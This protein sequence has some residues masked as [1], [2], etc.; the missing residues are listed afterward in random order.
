MNTEVIGRHDNRV[1]LSSHHLKKTIPSWIVWTQCICFAVLYAIWNYPLTNFLS[2]LCMIVGALLSVYILYINRDFFRTKQAIP[3]WLLVLLL[4]WV[5]FHLLFLSNNFSLQ[6]R[7]LTNIWKRVV[8]AIIFALGFG[9]ALANSKAKKGYWILFYIGMMAPALIFIGKYW[10]SISAQKYGWVVPEYLRIYSGRHSVFYMYKTDYVSFCLPALAITLA[11]LRSKLHDS[12][13]NLVSNFSYI[14]GVSAIM[15]TFYL[16]N[17]KNGMAYSM[18]LIGTFLILVFNFELNKVVGIRFVGH[19]AKLWLLK[20]TVILMLVLAAFPIASR[21]IEQNPSWSSIW[22]DSKVAVQVDRIDYWKYWGAKGYPLNERGAV[23]SA[24]NYERLAWGIVGLRLLQQNPLGY[25]LVQDSFGRLAK[26]NWPD[27]RL[28]QSHSGWLDLAL[29]LGIPGVGLL[30]TALFMVI[31]RTVKNTGK[32]NLNQRAVWSS[33]LI[34]VL[35]ALLLLWCTS[36]ISL[37]IH[38]IALLFWVSFGVGLA[39]RSIIAA[40]PIDESA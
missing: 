23:V 27:S 33:R 25:G 26:I 5:V 15:A 30:L 18:I 3:F 7:E 35:W 20:L 2:D 13:I 10:L 4:L 19:G 32:N 21:H 24:T 12:H 40:H 11:Q 28:T 6:L 9:M 17:I 1:D 8:I 16:G 38:V 14:L 22:V 39:S 34:W 29:G 37:K 31:C 36:E